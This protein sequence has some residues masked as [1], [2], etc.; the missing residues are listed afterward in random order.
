MANRCVVLVREKPTTNAAHVRFK[1][2]DAKLMA[3]SGSFLCSDYWKISRRRCCSK[4]FLCSVFVSHRCSE[5]N[6]VNGTK[7]ALMD[8]VV[9]FVTDE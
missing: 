6:A 7:S 8:E 4:I 3:L 2:V 1:T 5:W 9:S